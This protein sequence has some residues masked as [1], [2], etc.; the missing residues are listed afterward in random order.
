MWIGNW[1]DQ[2][3]LHK[4]QFGKQNYCKLLWMLFPSLFI[5]RSHVIANIA[6]LICSFKFQVSGHKS[7]GLLAKYHG[8]YQTVCVQLV[9]R[10]YR[11]TRRRKRFWDK[12]LFL[13]SLLFKRSIIWF[14]FCPMKCCFCGLR[15]MFFYWS[16]NYLPLQSSPG[17]NETW[18]KG[19]NNILT[20]TDKSPS[21]S[22]HLDQLSL[23]NYSCSC[24]FLSLSI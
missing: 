13:F 24:F 17:P 23:S 19:E 7:L 2:N 15:R 18:E 21:P 10:L 3:S 4:Y 12:L 20:K 5:Q 22:T 16:L 11:K 1:E 9:N 6:V 8:D 14:S